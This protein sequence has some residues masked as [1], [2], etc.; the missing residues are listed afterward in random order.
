MKRELIVAAAAATLYAHFAADAQAVARRSSLLPI[1]SAELARFIDPLIT[2]QMEKEHIPGAVFVLVQNRKI[3]YQQGYGF[4]DLATKKPVDPARTI[5]RIGSISKVFTATAVVQLA[6]RGRLRLD[7]DVN[8]YLT[9]F[10]V[11]ATYPEPGRFW[12]LLTHT[13]GF[14]EIRPGTRAETEAELLSLGDFLAPKLVRLRPPGRVISYSTYGMSLAGYLVEQVSGLDF[15]TYLRRNIWGPLGMTRASIK[16]PDSLKGDVAVGYEWDN[17]ANQRANWEWYHSTPASSINASGVDMGHFIIAQ[18]EGGRYG[19]TRIMSS[20]AARGMQRRHF[21]MHQ[22]L[23]GFAYGFF[24]DFANGQRVVEHGG[25]VEGFSAQLVLLPDY[26]IGFFI[27]SQHEPARLK[28]VVQKALIDHYFP[29]K[30]ERVRPTPMANYQSR[31]SRYAGT[32][33][34]NQF[35]HTCGADRREYPRAEVKAFPDG[36][37]SISG[38]ESHFVEVEP[39]V[40]RRVDGSPGSAVFHEGP[41]GHIDFLAGDAWLV[42]ERI[43]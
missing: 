11:A 37:I 42:A 8:R 12:H 22:S 14:D 43:K 24:E 30:R 1:D 41:A 33:E 20:R 13:A 26:N 38:N 23:A 28:D 6:D 35:C 31:A 15:E 39:L 3:L 9:R 10:K 29:D 2:A 16:V 34:L 25:N 7:D 18:L 19:P 32:Y 27:A 40:F 4:A 17:G 36:T 5:W 21:T